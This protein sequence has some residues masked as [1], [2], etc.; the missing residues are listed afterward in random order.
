MAPPLA[1]FITYSTYGT[2][3]HGRDGGSVDR[4][5]NIIGTPL[6]APDPR[7]EVRRRHALRQETYSLD[8]PRRE[9]VLRTLVEVCEHRRWTLHAAHV[10]TTHVHLVVAAAQPPEKVMADLKA[11]SSRRLR[12]AY[13]EEGDRDRCTQHGSTRYL[14]DAKSLDAAVAYVVDEQGEAMSVYDSRARESEHENEREA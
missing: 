5:H 3:L 14:N 1:Y 12:E 9:V 8:E 11:W 13:G 2:W 7:M 10:R 4:R 6:L